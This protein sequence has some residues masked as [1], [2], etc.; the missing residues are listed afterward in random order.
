MGVGE[1]KEKMKEEGQ[2]AKTD[3]ERTREKRRRKENAT[4]NLKKQRYKDSKW[5]RSLKAK[6]IRQINGKM[7]N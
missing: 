1:I 6:E 2:H 5:D 3:V 4:N 7:A